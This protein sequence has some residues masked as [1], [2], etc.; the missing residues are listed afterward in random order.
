MINIQYPSETL[1]FRWARGSPPTDEHYNAI[2]LYCCVIY[3]YCVESTY[4]GFSAV[5]SRAVF[6][7][8]YCGAVE[9]NSTQKC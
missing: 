8:I 2:N 5:P 7:Y 1:F 3:S 4:R 6:S 9:V